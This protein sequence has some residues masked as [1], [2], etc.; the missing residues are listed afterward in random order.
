MRIIDHKSESYC[1][2]SYL[3]NK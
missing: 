1:E 3:Q 2:T